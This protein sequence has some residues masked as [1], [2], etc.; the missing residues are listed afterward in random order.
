MHVDWKVVGGVTL[1][2]LLAGCGSSNNSQS[3]SASVGFGGVPLAGLPS[4]TTSTN[5]NTYYSKANY[6]KVTTDANGGSMGVPVPATDCAQGSLYC[7]MTGSNIIP[8]AYVNTIESNILTAEGLAGDSGNANLQD[9]LS[10]Q[11]NPQCD[12][13]IYRYEYKTVDGA[14]AQTMA[15]AAL[16]VPSAP[17]GASAAVVAQCTGPRPTL[18]YT[19]GTA[20]SKYY[21]LALNIGDSTNPQMI[22]DQDAAADVAELVANF[23][24][25]GYIVVAPNYA[26]YNTSPL[27]YHP[28]LN[29]DQQ[30]LDVVDSMAAATQ[31]LPKV[32]SDNKLSVSQSGKTYVTG[33]SQGGYVA[34]ATLQWLQ[35]HGQPATAGA[36]L[37]G[38][39]SLE[40]FGDSVF[41][42]AVGAG[43][44]LF[45]SMMIES[46]EHLQSG[47]LSGASILNP[48]FANADKVLPGPGTYT[49]LTTPNPNAPQPIPTYALFDSAATQGAYPLS[50]AKNQY[51]N[52]Q[53]G[54][55]SPFL[56]A[57][58]LDPT[59]YLIQDGFRENYL[60]DEAQNPDG[61][62]QMSALTSFS[63]TTFT[64][65]SN[66][67]T[68]FQNTNLA[69]A[70]NPQN[71]LRKILKRFD[72]RNYVPTMP[73]FMC[74]G[75][76]DPTVFF[77]QNE[78]LMYGNLA[79]AQAKPVSPLTAPVAMVD[80]GTPEVAVTT[81]LA[82]AAT[83]S[84]QS[85]GISTGQFP[86]PLNP[87]GVP[88]LTDLQA[89][90]QS[91]QANYLKDMTT[92]FNSG[93]SGTN[94]KSTLQTDVAQ[95]F[96]D[97][98]VSSQTGLINQTFA[99][100]SAQDV[101]G[102]D[103]SNNPWTNETAT[104]TSVAQAAATAVAQS[105]SMPS[106]VISAINSAVYNNAATASFLSGI[107][108]SAKSSASTAAGASGATQLSIIAAAASGA[109][110]DQADSS[111]AVSAIVSAA[112][113]MPALSNNP[114]DLP[115]VAA[116]AVYAVASAAG[117]EAGKAAADV[118][119]AAAQA[120]SNVFKADV[121]SNN[122]AMFGSSLQ[123]TMFISGGAQALASANL[124]GLQT[125]IG[126]TIETS[127][128]VAGMLQQAAAKGLGG[129]LTVSVATNAALADV[130]VGKSGGGATV[131]TNAGIPSAIAT[132]LDSG[133]WT[134]A[135]AAV[136]AANVNT[137]LFTTNVLASAR[138]AASS[139]AQAPGLIAQ[140]ENVNPLISAQPLSSAQSVATSE[141]ATLAQLDGMSGLQAMLKT[142]HGVVE[143]PYCMALAQKWFSQ[144]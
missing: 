34:M 25:Q 20:I 57:L 138:T 80:L 100:S 93:Y 85:L 142:I 19:H 103:P 132:A 82:N 75:A 65:S 35:N 91:A 139:A 26:G 42:G 77:L 17:V 97:A 74:G 12:T 41:N 15:S 144:Y 126:A 76:G 23:V 31:I 56:A 2:I 21:D 6:S 110:A 55:P 38:A 121:A 108:T 32:A 58:G 140:V 1:S 46:F 44:T 60:N 13:H 14:G 9:V 48:T 70:A 105:Q 117:S 114:N 66:L 84:S 137:S 53:S 50:Y 71:P 113:H 136:V 130:M 63:D 59:N 101:V 51:K 111:K 92:V 62:S 134:A 133:V 107:Y 72:L 5:A 36:T 79:Q 89:S 24:S 118:L 47:S 106:N 45:A 87:S 3:P 120:S 27:K 30:P 135:Q 18:V 94:Y 128:Y 109:A 122:S 125:S 67:A 8:A 81:T 10:I 95:A 88:K 61:A 78:V 52:P 116:S 28:Y 29:G 39:Y 131:L 54:G 119:N 129:V 86:T 98:F 99:N 49:S 40:N 4:N 69:T 11:A 16:M 68:Y 112:M 115:V 104:I 143:P 124:V 7:D 96:N 22:D 37:S 90:V 102:K 123:K 141:G 33:Y 64:N 73:L 43:S 83:G 127:T